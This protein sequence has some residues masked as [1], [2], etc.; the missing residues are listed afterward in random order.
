MARN[1]IAGI[2]VLVAGI[3]LVAYLFEDGHKWA[4]AIVGKV[5]ILLIW[6]LHGR[7][8]NLD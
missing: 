4:A 3:G 2:V 1:D 8:I 6:A 5:A 7:H